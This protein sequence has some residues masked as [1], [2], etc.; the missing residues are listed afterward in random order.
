MNFADFSLN[1]LN[2]LGLQLVSILPKL[3][4]ALLIWYV[5]KYLLWLAVSFVRRME[6]AKP[7]AMPAL[8]GT[9][10]V[11]GRVI[12]ILIIL[13]YLGIGRG[14]I[15]AITQAFA[16]AVAI[17]L[18]LSFGKALEPDAKKIVKSLRDIFND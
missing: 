16:Y 1:L 17:A 3:I 6:L 11:A 13:D 14:V 12:L 8:T 15:S 2:Q 18:G 4:L 7:K 9:I 5:G 10:E